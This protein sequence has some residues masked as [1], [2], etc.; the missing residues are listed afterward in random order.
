MKRGAGVVDV[1]TS[2]IL[3]VFTTTK[4]SSHSVFTVEEDLAVEFRTLSGLASLNA[5]YFGHVRIICPGARQKKQ[6]PFFW[7]HARPASVSLPVANSV[8]TSI[9]LMEDERGVLI[10]GKDWICCIA[11]VRV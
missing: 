9:A 3:N 11:G 10:G 2:F 1:L 4:S 5:A 6:P 8:G 7:N